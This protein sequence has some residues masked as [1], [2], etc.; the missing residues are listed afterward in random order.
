[1]AEEE[2]INL[3]DLL[4]VVVKR[5]M[6]ILKACA[7]A[8]AVSVVYS[9]TLPNIYSAS[10]KVLPPQK[11]SGGGLSALLGQM[12]GLASLAGG[13][14]GLT[15]SGELFLGILKSRSVADAVVKRLDLITMFEA[16]TADDARRTLAGAVQSKIGKD[17]II[18]VTAEHTD[19]KVA[20]QLANAMVEELGKRSVQ[21]NLTKA[22]TERVFLE[23]RID[24]VKQDLKQAED[25][26]RSFAERNK[27]IKV[28]SQASATISGVAKLKA[29][30]A[31][32]EVQ[33]AALRSYQTEES[34]EVKLLKTSVAKLK[35]QLSTEEGS[36]SG[37]S[38]PGVGRIPTLGLDYARLFREVKIQEAIFEQL[39]K[40]YEAAKLMEAKDASSLQVLDEAVVPTIKSKP[41][42][43]IIVILTTVTA[44]VLAVFL[45]FLLE[46]FEKMHPDDRAR[47][48][49]IKSSIGIMRR[50]SLPYDQ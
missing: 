33:L 6:L 16:E 24:L 30:I 38:I 8:I 13:M 27:T 17:G 15:G 42:R 19:P 31:A 44:F 9:L 47:W 39:T 7:V 28:E 25:A 49:E 21:L 40:Q 18:T 20:A 48:Q 32:F 37:G 3:L 43:S 34:P 4:K 29:E 36:G 14:G 35:G 26:L 5:K 45:A 1:M 10:A 2:E 50:K 22:G 11:D 12:G 46:Y 23:K 41:K